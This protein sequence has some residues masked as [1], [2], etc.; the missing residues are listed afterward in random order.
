MKCFIVSL[1]SLFAKFDF[2]LFRFL[3]TC[4]TETEGDNMT[5]VPLLEGMET[6]KAFLGK[7]NANLRKFIPF[8][9]LQAEPLSS[10]FPLSFT[11]RDKAYVP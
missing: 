9:T 11:A 5:F 1:I 3:S 7:N 4:L 8:I 10:L 6:N 2:R